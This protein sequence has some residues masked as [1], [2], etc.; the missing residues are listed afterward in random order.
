MGLFFREDDHKIE[1]VR[2]VGF[3]R[4]REVLE[5]SWKALYLVGFISLILFIPFAG[6]MVYAI[7]SKSGLLWS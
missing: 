1:G 5:G 4:Y 3:A 2:S 7:L 6:G